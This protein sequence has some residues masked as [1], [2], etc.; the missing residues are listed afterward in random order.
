[1]PL[2]INSSHSCM[3][4]ERLKVIGGEIG[5]LLEQN[6]KSLDQISANLSVLKPGAR[7][8]GARKCESNQHDGNSK[9]LV[10]LAMSTLL[11]ESDSRALKWLI[12]LVQGNTDTSRSCFTGAEDNLGIGNDDAEEILTRNKQ[13]GGSNASSIPVGL[14]HL[15]VSHFRRP[16]PEN[17]FDQEK[18]EEVEDTPRDA[19]GFAPIDPAFLDTL[20]EELRDEVLSGRQGLVAPQPPATIEP[21][22]DG[23]IDPE[24]LAAL[25]PDI[26]VLLTS[27]DA[28][29]ANLT[30]A[31]VAK[32][33][34]LRERFARRY[35]GHY[36]VCSQEVGGMSL[37]EE[38][39][40]MDPTWIEVVG[41][42]PIGQVEVSLLKLMEPL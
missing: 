40:E 11:S 42:L 39:K 31:L 4:Y 25:P 19:A 26:R 12:E 5:M 14:E 22:N 37:L 13:S 20:P 23:D 1:M 7:F 34:M 38:G 24:F 6:N 8:V 21:Q 30:P 2:A 9:G 27:S 32:V 36:L 41:S 10:L 28:V 17:P 15:L 29:L 18:L 3:L 33:N 16:T 35:I